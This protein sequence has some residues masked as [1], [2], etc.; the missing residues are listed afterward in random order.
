MWVWC[1]LSSYHLDYSVSCQ[2]RDP[3]VCITKELLGFLTLNLQILMKLAKWTGWI[4]GKSAVFIYFLCIYLSVV[5]ELYIIT[6]CEYSCFNLLG[7][8]S[9]SGVYDL[10]IYIAVI[11]SYRG[12]VCTRLLFLL[13]LPVF[14]VFFHIFTYIN[15]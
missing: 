6:N 5:Y 4:M 3:Y 8:S 7:C 13:L 15:W 2:V 1:K 14:H 9:C 10:L 12:Q 11:F